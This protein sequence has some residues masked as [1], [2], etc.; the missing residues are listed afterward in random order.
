MI[1]YVAGRIRSDHCEAHYPNLIRSGR[2]SITCPWDLT[3]PLTLDYIVFYIVNRRTRAGLHACV[4]IHNMYSLRIL[5][6][7]HKLTPS[8]PLIPFIITKIAE[9][10]PKKLKK[11]KIFLFHPIYT[12]LSSMNK[13]F[14]DKVTCQISNRKFRLLG[15]KK[16]IE[17]SF[18][19][20]KYH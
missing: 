11:P 6:L 5:L 7:S 20:L 8:S 18:D 19:K 15:Y 3:R 1:E 2:F 4:H 17:I 14:F 13:R 10:P 9:N 12:P 16:W